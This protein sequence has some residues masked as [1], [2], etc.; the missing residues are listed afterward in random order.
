MYYSSV[1][2]SIIGRETTRRLADAEIAAQCFACYLVQTDY[3]E[4]NA[5]QR[6]TY[7]GGARMRW[8]CAARVSSSRDL[9]RGWVTTASTHW[10][11]SAHR[12]TS[13][14]R[15]WRCLLMLEGWVFRGINGAWGADPFFNDSCR[16]GSNY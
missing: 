13:L 6:P 12:W 7:F 4:L 1:S 16:V 5:G 3:E 15:R 11:R 10:W 9:P 14:R 2:Y 8:A